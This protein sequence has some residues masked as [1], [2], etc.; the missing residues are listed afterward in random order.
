MEALNVLRRLKR[1]L[2]RV[3]DSSP[4]KLSIKMLS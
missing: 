1:E 2:G 3:P 4:V